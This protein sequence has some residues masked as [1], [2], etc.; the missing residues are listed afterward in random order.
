[1]SGLHLQ[2]QHV[3]LETMPVQH[4]EE[5]RILDRSLSERNDST[6]SCK[7]NLGHLDCPMETKAKSSIIL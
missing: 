3:L 1:M 2:K 6:L 4:L 5:G 7:K